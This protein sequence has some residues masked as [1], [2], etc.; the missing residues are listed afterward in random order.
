MWGR[1]SD[2]RARPSDEANEAL[3]L[4]TYYRLENTAG[5]EGGLPLRLVDEVVQLN[6][7]DVIGPKPLERPRDLRVRVV[8][9][10]LSGFR[11][12]EEVRPVC[13]HP[14]PDPQLCVAV[15]CGRVDVVDVVL[16]EQLHR[17]I[18]FGLR[19]VTESRGPEDGAGALVSSTSELQNRDHG[20]HCASC[21][22][23]PA[24]GQ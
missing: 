7:V 1:E 13:L 19:D 10:P 11:R 16:A 2:A 9:P 14:R 18:C 5:S 15:A 6:Q 17:V 3:I 8:T 4:R 22:S 24:F 21:E 23:G 12:Q 20:S